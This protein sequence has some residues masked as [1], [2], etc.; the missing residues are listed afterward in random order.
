MPSNVGYIAII[1]HLSHSITQPIFLPLCF[2]LV[3]LFNEFSAKSGNMKVAELKAK[4][5]TKHYVVKNR[6][7]INL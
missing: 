4:Q 2:S 5:S 1:I 6:N 3:H 7:V